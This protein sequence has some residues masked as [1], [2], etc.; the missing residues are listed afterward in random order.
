M[1]QYGADGNLVQI[2]HASDGSTF[3]QVGGDITAPSPMTTQSIQISGGTSLSKIRLQAK[4]A[5]SNRYYLDNIAVRYSNVLASYN[6]LSVNLTSQPVSGLSPNTNYY[7]RVRAVGGN[8]TSANSNT[9]TVLTAPAAATAST[10]VQPTCAV[11]TGT[12]VVTAPIGAYEY[13]IDG[14]TL[15]VPAHR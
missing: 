3:T 14:G 11:T 2:L 9:I 15:Y 6:N 7:Y 4:N 10:T 12:I 13:N 8:S 5:A 1:Q